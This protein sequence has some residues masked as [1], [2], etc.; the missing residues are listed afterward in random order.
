[1]ARILARGLGLMDPNLQR[2]PRE[3]RVVPRPPSL[4]RR[5]PEADSIQG[6]AAWYTAH[7]IFPAARTRKHECRARRFV[8]PLPPESGP[9][10]GLWRAGGQS[11]KLSGHTSDT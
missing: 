7:S 11:R 9:P 2:R 4:L 5:E 8:P 10:D 3:P 6:R 1:M